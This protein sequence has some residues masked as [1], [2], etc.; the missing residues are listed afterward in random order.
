[1]KAWYREKGCTRVL[2]ESTAAYWRPVYEVLEEEEEGKEPFTLV[3]ANAEAVKRVP[4]R[5]TD[6]SDARWLAQLGYFQMVNP[7]YV[8]PRGQRDLRD[9]LRLRRSLVE[10]HA[11]KQ[12]E[13]AELLQTAQV[14]LDSVVSDLFGKSG[15]AMLQALAD[16]EVDAKKLAKLALGSLKE[17]NAALVTVL[18][19]CFREHHRFQL[20]VL[21]G[22]I[23]DVEKQIQAVDARIDSTLTDDFQEAIERLIEIP[24]IGEETA[25]TILA[26]VG[27]DMT[28]FG[29]SER[30]CAWVGV[31]PGNNKSGGKR[32]RGK[33]ARTR[34]G[35]RYAKTAFAIAATA[36]SRKKGSWFR[37]KKFRLQARM[38]S[39]GKAVIAI[40][41]SLARVVFKLLSTPGLRFQEA[42][43]RAVDARAAQ[44][45]ITRAM[46]VL[47][48]FGYDVQLNA[49]APALP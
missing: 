45:Q 25:R 39:A 5:K 8:P 36:A 11:Q 12:N 47:N 29:T 37:D 17:K 4:G 43:I 35:N 32:L 1:M 3:L 10:T 20:G 9:L 49:R 44:S 38:G 28:V 2:M 46:K 27:T 6:F 24:G 14:K 31:V 13:V 48:G 15:R 23:A 21:L 42:D 19:G 40:A 41:H 34:K 7:S 33:G 22:L 26:E 30:F 18:D 16:G